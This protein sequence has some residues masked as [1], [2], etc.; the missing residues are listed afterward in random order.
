MYTV[1]TESPSL[2]YSLPT[3]D[4]TLTSIFILS[5]TASLNCHLLHSDPIRHPCINTAIRSASSPCAGCIS[6]DH[7]SM[8]MSHQ[9]AMQM[10]DMLAPRPP[11]KMWSRKRL[12]TLVRAVGKLR[13]N[14]PSHPLPPRLMAYDTTL[15]SLRNPLSLRNTNNK[16]PSCHRR[17]LTS[18]L[19]RFAVDL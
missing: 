10:P 8:N 16:Y 3:F 18:P 12:R 7:A 1:Y 19:S 9:T 15:E 5:P 13:Q 11:M 2:A 4:P 6:E 14:H 17:I